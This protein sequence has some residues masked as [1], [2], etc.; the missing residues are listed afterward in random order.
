MKARGNESA[1][2]E[3]AQ[4]GVNVET[5]KVKI[6]LVDDDTSILELYGKF[7]NADVF[8]K[9]TADSGKI[10]L[11]IYHAWHPDVIVLDIMMPGM[12][13]NEVLD[14]IRTTA[15]D[16][17]TKVVM[18]TCMNDRQHVQDCAKSGIQGYIVKP[19]KPKDIASKILHCIQPGHGPR[20]DGKLEVR[21]DKDLQDI[22]PGYLQHRRADVKTMLQAL[23]DRRFEAVRILGHSMRGSGGGYGFSEISLVGEELETAALHKDLEKLTVKIGEL[24]KYLEHIEVIY[25]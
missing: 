10:A 18:V 8:E 13:G 25:E 2:A 19:F 12:K 24:L 11:E 7:L 17:T 6:L 14:A 3:C 20:R 4:E 9:R 16:K 1:T 23:E 5:D 21:I 22:I 15:K